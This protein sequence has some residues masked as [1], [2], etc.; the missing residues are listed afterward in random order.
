MPS[1]NPY[2][3]VPDIDFVPETTEEILEELVDTYEQ[4]L[5]EEIGQAEKLPVASREKIILNT[6]AYELSVL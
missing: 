6:M 3:A 4:V 5:S 2:D 1:N